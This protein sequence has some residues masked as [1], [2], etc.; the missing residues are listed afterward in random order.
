M[1]HVIGQQVRVAKIPGVHPAERGGVPGQVNRRAHCN[2]LDGIDGTGGGQASIG[3]RIN[4]DIGCDAI[5]GRGWAVDTDRVGLASNRIG[6]DAEAKSADDD[7]VVRAVEEGVVSEGILNQILSGAGVE[8]RA[9][10]PLEPAN[11]QQV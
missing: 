4:E 8:I 10:A 5:G 11:G 9:A 3:R 7:L 2:S 6:G 1:G